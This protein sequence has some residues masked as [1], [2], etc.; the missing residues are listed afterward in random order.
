MEGA[1]LGAST[2]TGRA[3]ADVL[4]G[5]TG[6][7]VRF[8]ALHPD[9][10]LF[11]R[12]QAGELVV[13]V[14]EDVREAVRIM[15]AIGQAEG[16]TVVQQARAI[17]EVVGLPPTWAAA[18]SNLRREIMDGHAAAATSRR[19][20]AV[21]KAQIR[22]RIA[23]G[24]VTESF[25]E[26]MQARYSESLVN[27]RARNIARTETLRA[28]H[29][30]QRMGWEQAMQDG[31]LPRT[32]RRVVV[33]TPD[34]RLEHWMVPG[35]NEGGRGIDEPFQAPEGSFMNPPFR[36]LCRCGVGLIFPGYEGVL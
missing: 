10:V 25:A 30:G 34:H 9:V 32:A 5:A 14:S 8:N 19:L 36:P 23:K 15:L 26:S 33:V 29:H 7:T 35:M 12:Q 16:L 18:P 4:S 20:S 28:S 22:S 13:Q 3:G 11:A 17:R 6:T 1:L 21:E 27:R 31:A 2:T 24:T